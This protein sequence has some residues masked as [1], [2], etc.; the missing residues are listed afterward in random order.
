M[1]CRR[2]RRPVHCAARDPAA[3]DGTAQQ[4]AEVTSADPLAALPWGEVTG[5]LQERISTGVNTETLTETAQLL[6]LSVQMRHVSDAP[7]ATDLDQ[8]TYAFEYEIDGTWYAFERV[9]PV[10]TPL[11]QSYASLGPDARSTIQAMAPGSATWTMLTVPLSGRSRSLHLHAVTASGPGRRFEPKP[12]AHVVRVRLGPAV[13][14]GRQAPVSTAVT[15]SLRTPAQVDM[16]EQ[17]VDRL[18]RLFSRAHG[19]VR[20]EP[21]ASSVPRR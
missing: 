9:P 20:R 16:R 4:P 17:S 12:G 5:G 18:V 6:Y 7:V 15:V 2:K 10:R 11:T 8:A 1:G 14:P 3:V 13:V 21:Q 19:R